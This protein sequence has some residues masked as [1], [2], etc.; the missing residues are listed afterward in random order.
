MAR[1]DW[2]QGSDG[3]NTPA[4]ILPEND[5]KKRAPAEESD[6]ENA[7]FDASPGT[8]RTS[9]G[10]AYPESVFRNPS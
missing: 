8:S 2:G 5:L 6:Q 3:D 10:T 7:T 1:S 9:L 4:L